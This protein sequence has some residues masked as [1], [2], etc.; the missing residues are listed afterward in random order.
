MYI[1]RWF[2]IVIKVGL[3]VADEYSDVFAPVLSMDEVIEV[4]FLQ[5]RLVLHV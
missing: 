3:H 4:Y 5:A 1:L 2:V